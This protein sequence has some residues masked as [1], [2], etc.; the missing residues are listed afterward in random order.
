[1]KC[2]NNCKF[3]LEKHEEIKEGKIGTNIHSN[4]KKTGIYA[5]IIGDP[6]HV[7]NGSYILYH[8][9]HCCDSYEPRTENGNGVPLP[10]FGK[11]QYVARD[12]S[13]P[14][15]PKDVPV[16]ENDYEDDIPW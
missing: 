8:A 12:F 15:P 9:D 16:V 5:K 7:G 14:S 11:Q 2:C 6:Y 4:C 10:S 1:M 3:F 13:E